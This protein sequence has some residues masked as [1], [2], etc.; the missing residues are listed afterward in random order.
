MA[1]A[2]RSQYENLGD[3]LFDP[4][5]IIPV[6]AGPNNSKTEMLL[7]LWLYIAGMYSFHFVAMGF[8][9]LFFE[10][11]SH[12]SQTVLKQ[13]VLKLA[14]DIIWNLNFIVVSCLFVCLFICLEAGSHVVQAGHNLF[15]SKDDLKG[16]IFLLVSLALTGM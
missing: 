10:A 1:R 2:F 13:A 3:S 5:M 16:L 8:V 7:Y 9:L 15:G 12:L 6:F 14:L 4:V 11:G